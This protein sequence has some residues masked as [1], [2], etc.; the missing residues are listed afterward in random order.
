MHLQ[1]E[2]HNYVTASKNDELSEYC[3]RGDININYALQI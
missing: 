1:K 2:S 3:R